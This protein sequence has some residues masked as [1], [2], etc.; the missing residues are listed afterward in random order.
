MSHDAFLPKAASV[1]ARARNTPNLETY[2]DPSDLG[3]TQ[4]LGVGVSAGRPAN[5]LACAEASDVPRWNPERT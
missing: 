2:C 1:L 5:E 4:H 3:Q